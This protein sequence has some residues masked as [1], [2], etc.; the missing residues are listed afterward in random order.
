MLEHSNYISPLVQPRDRAKENI[1]YTPLFLLL[2]FSSSTIGIKYRFRTRFGAKN[3]V[4]IARN[5]LEIYASRV[6]T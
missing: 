5:I 2:A 1:L 3:L 6:V 4:S